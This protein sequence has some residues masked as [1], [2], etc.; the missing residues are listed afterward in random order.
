MVGSPFRPILRIRSVPPSGLTGGG[1][2]LTRVESPRVSNL[3]F[4][5]TTSIESDLISCL[6]HPHSH[7]STTGP[8]GP[9]ALRYEGELGPK[10][11]AENA[12]EGAF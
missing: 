5:L 2:G 3:V 6:D 1:A 8:V 11:R 7:F 10:A 4:H 9:A 12:A